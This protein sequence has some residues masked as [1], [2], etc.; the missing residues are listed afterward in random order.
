MIISKR[1]AICLIFT[2]VGSVLSAQSEKE[3]VAKYTH[4]LGQM[5][6]DSAGQTFT[7]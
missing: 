3:I 7:A 1:L 2:F 6:N 5:S 4:A